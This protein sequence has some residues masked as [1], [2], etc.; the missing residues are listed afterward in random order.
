M[1]L[2]I[3]PI[4][5]RPRYR[6]YGRARRASALRRHYRKALTRISRSS[7][8]RRVR[9]PMGSPRVHVV[10]QWVLFYVITSRCATGVR[11]ELACPPG[12]E[13]QK[14]NP[15]RGRVGAGRCG[16]VRTRNILSTATDSEDEVISPRNRARHDLNRAVPTGTGSDDGRRKPLRHAPR[17]GLPHAPSH[18]EPARRV[19]SLRSHRGCKTPKCPSA[20]LER[21]GAL[22]RPPVCR[23]TRSAANGTSSEKSPASTS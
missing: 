11:A 6:F 15:C 9:G 2:E 22:W 4:P 14:K 16:T 20:G 3:L 23:L 8:A 18:L 13:K 7:I 17:R 12:A 10:G 19:S 1:A 5:R 21:S